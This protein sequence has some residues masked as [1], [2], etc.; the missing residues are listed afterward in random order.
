MGNDTELQVQIELHWHIGLLI[1][2]INAEQQAIRFLLRLKTPLFS[3][4]D[5]GYLH[6]V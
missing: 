5:P 1:V 4:G 3:L 2:L 6:L